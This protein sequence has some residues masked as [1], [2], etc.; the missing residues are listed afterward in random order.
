MYKIVSNYSKVSLIFYI[1]SPDF[2]Y[3]KVKIWTAKYDVAI[4]FHKYV[5]IHN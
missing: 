4:I 1:Y 3:L 5:G 2:R